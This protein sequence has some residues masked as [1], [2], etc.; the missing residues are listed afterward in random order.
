MSNLKVVIMTQND[1]FFIPKN[2][3]KVSRVCD[4]VEI[5][6]VDCK[7][8]LENKISDYYKWF[9]VKQCVVM[10]L[11][12]IKRKIQMICDRIMNYKIY[13]GTCSVYDISKAIKVSYRKINNS[14]SDS[15]INHIR[16]INPDLIVSFSAPQIL[17]EE[18]LTIPKYGIIN[19]HG[20]LLPDYRGCLPS[21]WYL[22]NEEKYGGA[23]VH[24][25]SSKIDDGDIIVQDKIDISECKTMFSLISKTKS[26]GGDL[27]V[28]AIIKISNQDFVLSKNDTTKGSYYTWPTVKEA[29]IFAKKGY[30]LI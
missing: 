2:I 26:L 18:L 9:G 4:L 30:K 11:C 19:V 5:V 12:V 17:K 29:K 25:M 23:T 10:G 8:S 7:S 24:Y 15:F 6:E 28:N 20:S 27:M 14:N 22:F 13:G 21:F 16:D 1:I 3:K